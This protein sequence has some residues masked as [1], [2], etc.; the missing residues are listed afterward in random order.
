MDESPPRPEGRFALP[1]LY[2]AWYIA[3][4]S[5]ELRRRPLRRLLFGVPLALFRDAGGRPAALV[6]RCAHRNVPL[7]AGRCIGGRV[8]CPYHGW[9]F[10]G[11][12]V[13]RVIPGLVGAHEGKARRVPSHAAHEREG[14]VWVWG[15]A[16]S[17]PAGR[18]PAFGHLG[19]P[20]YTVVRY[21][22]ELAST[23]H[24]AL[25][26]VLDVPHTAF[27]HRG[28]FRGGGRP[29]RVRVRV[30]GLAAGVEA[31]YIGE[32]RPRGLLGRLLAPRGGTV[33]HIDRFLL[34]SIA[35]VEYAVGDDS[36][37]LITNVLTP[38]DDFTTRMNVVVLLRL[39]WGAGLL[40]RLL[41]PLAEHVVAQDARVL[42][43][44]SQNT[45]RFG[46]EQFVSTQ[47]DVLSP[48]VLRLLRRTERGES[49][50][51]EGG[52]EGGESE[53]ELLA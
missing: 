19:E 13:C 52:R 31:E 32:P 47:V 46:G 48:Y 18:P 44:Q 27:L 4:R 14:Y 42:R 30:Q 16:D 29:N 40:A 49:V 22:V 11:G 50:G 41:A 53:I 28:L 38:V 21:E 1:R 43:L 39:A 20:G 7:S 10:D 15:R 33:R 34:P 9:Q 17:D 6:D 51:G 25:E 45:R 36:H 8:E 2:D 23:L 24:N 5:R 35:Q 3:C 12:G 37:L 26:N